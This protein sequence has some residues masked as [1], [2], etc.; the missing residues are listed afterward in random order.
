[1]KYSI[2]LLRN[3]AAALIAASCSAYAQQ[4]D[5]TSEAPAFEQYSV[6]QRL[7]P[8]SGVLFADG[9]NYH[10][11]A[12]TRIWIDG[13]EASRTELHSDMIG[14]EIGI[15]AYEHESR[16]IVTMLHVLP[17]EDSRRQNDGDTR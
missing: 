3:L 5:E 11:Q 12:E 10:L 7:D 6:I 17:N 2:F 13:K 8:A 1:M 15:D 4:V 9:R 16:Y 14:R